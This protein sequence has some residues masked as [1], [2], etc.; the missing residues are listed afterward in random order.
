[1]TKYSFKTKL[2]ISML[3][4]ALAP[5][6]IAMGVLSFYGKSKI[7]EGLESALTLQTI[8]MAKEI[9]GYFGS[10]SSEFK[11]LVKIEIMDDAL[12]GDIDKRISV[13]LAAKKQDWK[14]EGELLCVS[15]EG[16]VVASTIQSLHGRAFDD[17]HI[18]DGLNQPQYMK[19]L[20]YRAF[21]VSEPIMA[22]F[23]RTL[24][25]GRLIMVFKADNFASKLIV[26]EQ[27]ES[28]LHNANSK[29]NISLS[30]VSY[31]GDPGRSISEDALHITAAQ[32]I[33]TLP[34]WFVVTQ[35]DKSSAFAVLDRFML[36]LA[37][38][39]FAGAAMIIVVSLFLSSKVIK[40]IQVL[41]RTAEDIGKEHAFERRVPVESNDEIGVL[42]TVFNQMVENIQCSL[43]AIKKENSER[44]R[45]FV[46]LIE[47]FKKI[48]ASMSEK[49][50][51]STAI[52]QIGLFWPTRR[53]LFYENSEPC[54]E[55]DL[56]A[57]RGVS[58]DGE[59]R[60]IL[61][62]ISVEGADELSEEERQ[63]FHS[64]LEMVE[65]QIERIGLWKKTEA[66]SRAKSDFIANMSHELRTPLN[67]VIGFSQFLGSLDDFPAQYESIPKNIETAGRHLLSL[68]ND[69]L[70]MA[71]I[72]AGKIEV[73]KEAIDGEQLMNEIYAISSSL[74]ASKKI[75][76]TIEHSFEGLFFSDAKLLK[77]ILLNLLSNAIK[78]TE[79]GSVLLIAKDEGERIRFLVKD[80]GIG[81]SADDIARLFRDFTQIENP[82]QKKYKGTGLGLSLCKKLAVCLEGDV[83]IES[84]GAGKGSTA[85]LTIPRGKL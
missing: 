19:F 12:T 37:I 67:S 47:M 81:L 22:S 84:E 76:F 73:E 78:F 33:E 85:I 43:E 46:A 45:L 34:G 54:A 23:E 31:E 69:I 6:M 58:F 53:I 42:S 68:I 83:T 63:F 28:F 40:P 52:V 61:G 26:D 8:N 44:L 15:A 16:V 27:K 71:K 70:D 60:E 4:A 51:I 38:A 32:K 66:A 62:C 56:F 5:Y 29:E 48:T 65:L 39:L 2:I 41:S 59:E 25:I 3:F 14:L 77:Q 57:L 30:P 10:L 55:G 13:L 17:E 72:E 75:T 64:I 7:K 11:S 82:L 49:D 36:F 74:I 79:E 20:D 1:M 9:G 24:P 35:S 21:A 80:S 50:T 18:K